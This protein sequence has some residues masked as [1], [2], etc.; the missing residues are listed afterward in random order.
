MTFP[1]PII[2]LRPRFRL[3]VMAGGSVRQSL[4]PNLPALVRGDD[5][6]IPS[7][8]E[9]RTTGAAGRLRQP[10]VAASAGR[11]TIA[12]PITLMR[13]TTVRT[14]GTPNA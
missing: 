8:H 14:T 1:S 9:S 7:D 6:E 10:S 4:L 12:I 13:K 2:P 5:P 11:S 3:G